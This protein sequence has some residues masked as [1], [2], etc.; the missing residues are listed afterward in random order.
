MNKYHLAKKKVQHF[1]HH[2]NKIVLKDS[3]PEENAAKFELFIFD[4]LPLANNFA[5]MEVL[6]ENEFAPIKNKNEPGAVDCPDTAKN[7]ISKL[8]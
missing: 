8:H 5:C 6:R 1:D 4:A 7:I 2:N 3:L